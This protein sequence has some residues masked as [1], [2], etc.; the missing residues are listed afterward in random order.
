MAEKPASE[1][2][3]QP[4]AKRIRKAREKG[5]VAQSQELPAA[6]SIVVLVMAL[7]LTAPSL[8]QWFIM[9]LRQGLSCQ[10]DVF[11]DSKTF[12]NYFNFNL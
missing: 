9:Q 12:I 7:T 2:T 1:K 6:V 8:L 3:E 11:V 10:T 4:K 5:Q